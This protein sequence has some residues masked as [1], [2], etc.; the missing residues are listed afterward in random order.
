MFH[1]SLEFTTLGALLVP[2]ILV[3]MEAVVV[4]AVV[5]VVVSGLCLRSPLTSTGH[6]AG[7]LPSSSLRAHMLECSCH[8]SFQMCTYCTCIYVA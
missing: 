2:S 6:S 1:V 7:V 3:V 8:F 5:V 4:V